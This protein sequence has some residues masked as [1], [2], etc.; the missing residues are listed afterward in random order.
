MIEIIPAILAHSAK[1]FEEKLRLVETECKT[2][3]VDIL[4]GTMFANTSWFDVSHISALKTNLAYELHIMAENPIPIIEEWKEKIPTLKRVI[5]HS[6][7]DRQLGTVIDHLKEHLKL[8]VGIA[9]NP[10]TPIEEIR[11]VIERIDQI[12]LMGVHPGTSG[13]SFEGDYL[14]DKIK[15]IHRLYPAISLEI[16][17]GVTKELIPA[18]VDAGITRICGASLLYKAEN[19]TKTLQELKMFVS[20]LNER[21]CYNKSANT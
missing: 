16:D 7:I 17:G 8:E 4:D 19:P 6:E 12:T 13:Q 10:A 11:D 9:L 5:I 3:Q 2:V 20:T 21:S 1:D 15:R 18:L 14:L